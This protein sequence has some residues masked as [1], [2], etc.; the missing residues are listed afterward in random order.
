MILIT[1]YK[2]LLK[3][4]DVPGGGND[5]VTKMESEQ[6]IQKHNILQQLKTRKWSLFVADEVHTL[7]AA[8]FQTVLETLKFK[9]KI[10]LTATPYREDNKITN[11]YYM[12][13][14]KLYE[15]NLIDLIQEGYLAKPYMVEMRCDMT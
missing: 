11:L 9:C 5:D 1:T 3:L 10:G 13:G 6:K 7:P 12:I 2:M 14:P 8:K 4:H 15:E